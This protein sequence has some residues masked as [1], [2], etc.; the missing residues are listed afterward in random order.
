MAVAGHWNN[1]AEA[2]K[3]TQSMLLQGV[4][5]TVIE[6]GGLLSMLP[7]KQI[8]GQDLVYNREK[9]W[10]TTTG[11]SS[12]AIRAS[13]PWTDDV[14][15]D[16]VTVPLKRFIRQDP[17]DKFIAKTY[18]SHNDYRALVIQEVTKRLVR[19]VENDFI[20]GDTTY[21]G[22]EQT[23]GLHAMA[24]ELS[25]DSDIDGL[26]VALSLSNLRK[27]ADSCKV[28][29]LGRDNVFFL[30]SRQIARRLDAGYQ[31][32][33]FVRTNVT[34]SMSSLTIGAKE[35]GGRIRFF[36]GI[37]IIVSDLLVAEQD[38]TGA[39]SSARAK[40]SSGTNTY[41]IFLVRAGQTEEGGVS[42]L[43]GDP[44]ATPNDVS[45][46][47]HESFPVLENYDSGGERL[48]GYLAPAL[49]STV[50]LGRIYDITDAEIAP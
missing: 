3:L 31:E 12:Y 8:T 2:Q 19:Q 22:S 43:F 48:V 45:P 34:H 16:Q 38:G 5:D 13:I 36:D 32:S 24:A 46:F 33:A 4:I 7:V 30:V 11:G 40:Q 44:D 42:V 50:S 14:E 41:S 17:W 10:T 47:R 39:G 1:L 15:Y 26:T 25:G 20:Y 29:Q 37:P 9:S 28:D 27:L 35:I 23:D 6:R 21:G 49:G 18:N